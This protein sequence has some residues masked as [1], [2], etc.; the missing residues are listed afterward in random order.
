MYNGGFRYTPFDPILSA[1]A[2]QYIPL[3]NE[4]WSGQVG[5]YFRIDARISYR[6]SKKAW[7]GNISLDV[8]N[9]TSR[10]NQNRA[11][12]DASKNELTISH[13]PGGDFIPVLA[14]TFD[15]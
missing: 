10:K 9:V 3:R 15:F 11:D 5:P 14:F 8:Q 7:G 4:Y 12:Y 1:E 6:Y 13:Y 2:G